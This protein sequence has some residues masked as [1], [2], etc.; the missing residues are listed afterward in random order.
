MPDRTGQLSDHIR[1]HANEILLDECKSVMVMS[2]YDPRYLAS[3]TEPGLNSF[4]F[5]AVL[6]MISSFIL[7]LY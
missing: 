2:K 6:V 7:I 5:Y 3:V 1:S 4:F